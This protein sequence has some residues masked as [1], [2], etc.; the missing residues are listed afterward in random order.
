MASFI[1]AHPAIEG[2]R[3]RESRNGSGLAV[4]RHDLGWGRP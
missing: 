4:L 2:V 1:I 3:A